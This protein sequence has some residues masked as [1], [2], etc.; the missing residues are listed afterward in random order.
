MLWF[1][2]LNFRIRDYTRDEV[3]DKVKG[4]KL[5]Q[6]RV[7]C[8]FVLSSRIESDEEIQKVLILAEISAYLKE[9]FDYYR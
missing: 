1:G 3:I 2:D 6:L 4:K 9:L 7:Q 8:S 5:V